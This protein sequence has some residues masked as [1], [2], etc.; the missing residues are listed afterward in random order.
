M[1]NGLQKVESP[2]VLLVTEAYNISEGQSEA[3]F[4]NAV[5][6]IADIAA[7]YPHVEVAVADPTP[8]GVAKPL[9]VRKHPNVK[10]WHLP[11]QSYDGQKNF[12]AQNSTHD[13]V[14][15]LDGDCRPL[16]KNWFEKILAPFADPAVS[17]V[18]GLTLYDDFSI[19]GMAMTILD[20]GFL[21]GTSGM[22]LG[23]YASNN[24]AFRRDTLFT[25]PMPPDQFMRSACYKHAQLLERAGKAIRLANEAVVLHELPDIAKERHRRG[26]DH[27]MA[28]WVDP[29][30]KETQLLANPHTAAAALQLLNY[31]AALERLKKAPPELGLERE[32]EEAVKEKI[33]WLMDIDWLGIEE[34]LAFG[35]ANGLNAKA[36]KEHNALHANDVALN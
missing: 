12:I 1:P 9:L 5:S 35:E 27:V 16:R 13:I 19:T 30:L 7:R 23:C 20:F 18:G 14:V 4:L 34:A 2:S 36:V 33:A 11:E 29:Y 28:L 26:Y 6:E 8:M 31:N 21:F 10:V 22:S 17:A 25:I 24:I 32:D 15:Y 3:A